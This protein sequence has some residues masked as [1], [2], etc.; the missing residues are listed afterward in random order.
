MARPKSTLVRNKTNGLPF[1]HPSIEQVRLADLKLPERPA[2]THNRSQ[3]RK[4]KAI[5]RAVGFIDPVVVDENNRILAGVLRFEVARDLGL[6]TIPVVQI[7]H[8]SELEKRTYVLAA[9]R[10]AE[11]AGWDREVLAAELGELSVHLAELDIDL[12]ATG[13]DVAELDLLVADQ[14]DAGAASQ[15]VIPE[16][17]P[18]VSQRGNLWVCGSHRILCG[19]ALDSSSYK[20]LLV[21]SPVVMVIADPPF[22]VTINNHARGS[23]KGRFREFAMASGE[24]TDAQYLA[25]LA[26][27]FANLR[28]ICIDGAIIF[29]FI[30]DKHLSHLLKAADEVGLEL[31]AICAWHKPNGGMGSLYRQQMEFVPV[32]KSGSAA[33]INNV[34]LG[35]H[36]RNRTTV[37]PYGGLSSISA[38]REGAFA[39]H[40]PTPKPV[41]LIAD[42]MLDCSRRGSLVLDPFLGSGTALIAGETVGRTVAGMELDPG[43]VDL[44]VK[45][46]EAFTG[47][48]AVLE[49]S[50]CTF[51]EVARR[52]N[53]AVSKKREA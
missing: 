46:W 41:R 30:D 42:A 1:Q 4:L 21:D 36:G 7:A 44:S 25:F 29:T 3:H 35:K 12:D 17:G 40:H 16:P 51:S 49:E 32:L 45:R 10:L 31:K 23:S 43:Y 13:F 48:D 52:R 47:R 20:V 37:W 19:D 53:S 22:N 34:E 39:K 24:M 38:G 27:Y 14:K 28:R 8:L 11:D 6:T 2:R 9:N 50:G 15:D 5:L 33:H 26:K 18:L